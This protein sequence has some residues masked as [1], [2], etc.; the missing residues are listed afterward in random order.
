LSASRPVAL[1]SVRIRA[2]DLDQPGLPQD[3]TGRALLIV[4]LALAADLF[5]PWSVV[6]GQHQTLPVGGGVAIAFLIGLAALP[7]LHPRL[8]RYTATAAVPLVVGGMCLGVGMAFWANLGSSTAP[9]EICPG[10]CPPSVLPAQS[11]AGPDFGLVVFLIGAIL[12]VVVGY[13]LFL[14]SARASLPSGATT[15]APIPTRSAQPEAQ[16]PVQDRQPAAV[17]AI[18]ADETTTATNPKAVSIPEVVLPGSDS[19]SR[20][21]DPPPIL[22][23]RAGS[24]RRSN[25]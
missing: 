18:S 25:R 2:G 12:V 14:D 24:I 17:A 19:W 8:R 5:L 16:Q 4:I 20:T 9:S 1:A 10:F 11:S 3:A 21:M 15:T 13:R 23:P 7:L 6:D 22:R